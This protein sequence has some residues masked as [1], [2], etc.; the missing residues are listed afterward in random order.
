VVARAVLATSAAKRGLQLPERDDFEGV[1]EEFMGDLATHAR[2]G[3][4]EQVVRLHPRHQHYQVTFNNRKPNRGNMLV[5]ENPS[6]KTGT[7]VLFRDSF[8]QNMITFFAATFSR[9]VFVWNPFVDYDLVEEE[10]PVLVL[11]IM[12]GR[13]LPVVPDDVNKFSWEQVEMMRRSLA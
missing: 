10:H 13:L 12:A 4:T 5:T 8:A 7:A 11:N 1:P 6:V 2:A 3:Q 9:C